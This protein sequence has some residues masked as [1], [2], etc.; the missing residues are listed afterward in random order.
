ARLAEV[1]EEVDQ[2]RAVTRGIGVE[3][4][5]GRGA[6]EDVGGR[7]REMRGGERD[8]RSARAGDDVEVRPDGGRD[9]DIE[10]A[11]GIR[12]VDQV[13]EWGAR[14][15]RRGD[16]AVAAYVL[17]LECHRSVEMDH[18]AG[19]ERRLEEADA[20]SLALDV[21]AGHVDVETCSHVGGDGDQED[22]RRRVHPTEVDLAAQ[23][24][25]DMK[26]QRR[27]DVEPELLTLLAQPE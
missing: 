9:V 13:A 25:G 2:R 18:G 16:L 24:A 12:V 1:L 8:G 26:L 11:G 4:D 5:S 15:R 14:D 10:G 21:R 27:V 23:M 22:R 3:R 7:R 20:D 17:Q 6:V 19:G